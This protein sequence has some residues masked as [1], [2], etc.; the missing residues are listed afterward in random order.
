M[1]MMLIMTV[2]NDDLTPQV[3]QGPQRGMTRPFLAHAWS[4]GQR[5]SSSTTDQHTITMRH[6]CPCLYILNPAEYWKNAQVD[7]SK[8]D[9]ASRVGKAL[10]V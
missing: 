1:K 8:S 2:T 5:T 4:E 3:A 9:G 6:C 7:G 10:Q